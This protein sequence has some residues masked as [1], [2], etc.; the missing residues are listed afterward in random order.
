MKKE[1]LIKLTVGLVLIA[2]AVVL[3]F[4]VRP[5]A[6][7]ANS[8]YKAAVSAR[9]NC[10]EALEEA[11]K[12]VKD[13]KEDAAEDVKKQAQDG[14]KAAAEAAHTAQLQ[15][16]EK[17][18]AMLSS[19]LPFALGMIGGLLG[20][21]M[22]AV[23]LLPEKKETED[24]HSYVRDL[25][26]TALFAALSYVGFK[27]LGIHFSMG[28]SST[29]LHMGNMFCVLAALLLGGVRGGIAGAI[30][31]TIGDLM[32]P[33]Y[34]IGAPKTF[35]LKFLIG[36]ITGLVAHTVFKI[37]RDVEKRKLSM[38]YAV[39]LSSAAGMAFNVVADPL[40]GYFYK[41][42]ILGIPQTI[43]ETWAKLNAV[44]TFINASAAVAVAS[45]LYLGVRPALKKMHMLP[46]I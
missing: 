24:K 39:A 41:V 7:D 12:K 19:V 43:A 34:M 29:S 17:K 16:E 23:S 36:L 38:P 26:L 32:M 33:Q 35:L 25:T 10:E 13:L 4:T 37:S 20:I 40:A 11:D 27:Y 3:M 6:L 8:A 22:T 21:V 42:Y 31:M 2:V 1:K 15:E 9:K 28:S 30:G 5:K 46:E 44:T 14:Q 18:S 45:L